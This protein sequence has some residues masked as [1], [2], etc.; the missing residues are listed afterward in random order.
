MRRPLLIIVV[1]A[2]GLAG[3]A[4]LASRMPA[5][6]LDAPAPGAVPAVPVETAA[7][8]AP[9]AADLMASPQVREYRER[10]AFE[11]R[12]RHFL[13]RASA[14]RAVERDEQAR[15]LEAQIDAYEA[16]RGLSAGEALLLRSGLID[17]TVADEAQRAERIAALMERYRLQAEQREARHL[18]RQR[19]DPRHVDYKARER[20]IVAEVAGMRE[21]PDGLTRD[22]YLRQRLQAAREAAY[23]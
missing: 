8:S 23:R 22:Q 13:Q 17:A 11:D 5:S 15:A 3:A 1:V 6:G 4:G 10:Q 20:A 19:N 9:E 12:M 18:A 7:R 21:F 2:L 14:L 16:T